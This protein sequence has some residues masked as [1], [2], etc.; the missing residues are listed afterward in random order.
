MMVLNVN[1]EALF[2]TFFFLK[3]YGNYGL[4]EIDNMLPIE[5]EI[6]YYMLIGYLKRKKGV[7]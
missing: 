2:N 6:Y 5:L 7:Q 3:I 1:L 4:E